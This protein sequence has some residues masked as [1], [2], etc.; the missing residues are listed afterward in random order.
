MKCVSVLNIAPF[1]LSLSPIVD[2]DLN[3]VISFKVCPS[4]EI[5]KR[6][7]EIVRYCY[8][9]GQARHFSPSF[10]KVDRS[11]IESAQL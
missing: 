1:Q 8:G 5:V 4:T 3:F 2:V 9:S 10:V 11:V 6:Y 7:L